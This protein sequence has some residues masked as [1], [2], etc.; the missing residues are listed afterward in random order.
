MSEAKRISWN[1][2]ANAHLGAVGKSTAGAAMTRKHRRRIRKLFV[3]RI[4]LALRY[5]RDASLGDLSFAAEKFLRVALVNANDKE[6]KKAVSY[7]LSGHVGVVV[8]EAVRLTRALEGVTDLGE[9]SAGYWRRRVLMVIHEIASDVELVHID[10]ALGAN[11]F[12]QTLER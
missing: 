4:V 11:D 1:D 12:V 3:E 7:S 5:E 6:V 9:G 2:A 8:D 10:D